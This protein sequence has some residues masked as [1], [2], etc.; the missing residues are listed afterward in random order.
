MKL[1]ISILLMLLNFSA[2]AGPGDGPIV[3][4]PTSID[5]ESI[6]LDDL[7]GEWVAFEHNSVWHIQIRGPEDGSDYSTIFISSA[8]LFTRK[9]TGWFAQADHI[10]YG[11]LIMD[12]T[13]ESSFVIF[14][15][16]DGTKLRLMTGPNRFLDLKLFRTK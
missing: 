3:P 7:Q 9:A 5:R 2:F 4:W 6:D 8:A 16:R 12:S 10:F 14:K 13:H 11:Q 1:L 15:D